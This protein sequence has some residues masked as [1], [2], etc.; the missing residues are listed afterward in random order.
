[1]SIMKKF[2]A[3]L[4]AF[5]FVLSFSACDSKTA[6]ENETSPAGAVEDEGNETASADGSSEKASVPEV[7]EEDMPVATIEL[8]DGRIIRFVMRPDVAPNTVANFISLASS[9]YYDGV[10]FHRVIPGFMVQTGDPDGSGFGGPGYVIKGEFSD[11]G[12][13]NNISHVTGTVS[14]ARKSY[15]PDTAGSQFFICVENSDFLDGQY[16]AFGTVIEGIDVA[17]DI[18]EVKRDSNNKPLEDIVIKSVT[19]DT[20]GIDYGEPVTMS[21]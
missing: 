6:D 16:A 15:S 7:S 11:N 3:L 21:E 10:I 2:I 14:M 12:V 8:E 17:V 19:V 9:G 20:H 5:V 18:S 13:D 1:M 4:L